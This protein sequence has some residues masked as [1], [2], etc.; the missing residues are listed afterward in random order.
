[1]VTKAMPK[2]RLLVLMSRIGGKKK[3]RAIDLK[4]DAF[5]LEVDDQYH[6]A[7]V[8]AVLKEL[9]EVKKNIKKIRDL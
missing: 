2:H 8:D 6:R 1:M 9:T 4:K 3:L 7:E 5:V